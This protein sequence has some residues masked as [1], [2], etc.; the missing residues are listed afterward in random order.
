MEVTLYMKDSSYVD[1][2]TGETRIATRFFLMVGTQL[3]PI[4]VT[5]FENQQLGR[6]PQF[7]GRKMLLKAVAK[8]LPETPGNAHGQ[9]E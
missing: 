3:V 9:G 5:Y 1:K 7:A 4:Q 8:P 6:D 2:S